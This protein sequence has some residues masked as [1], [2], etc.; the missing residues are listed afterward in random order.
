[1]RGFLPT[2]RNPAVASRP[3]S[4][5][6]LTSGHFEREDTRRALAAARGVLHSHGQIGRGN[7]GIAYKGKLGSAPALVKFAADA[8]IHGFPW[9]RSEQTKNLMQEAGVANELAALGFTV[10]P[11]AVYVELGDGT[12]AVVREYGEPL[13]SLS[14]AEYLAL[15][16]Q[17]TDIERVHGW[18]VADDLQLYRRADG[19]I[20]VADVGYWRAPDGHPWDPADSMLSTYFTRVQEEFMPSSERL[21]PL[22]RMYVAIERLGKELEDEFLPEWDG[23]DWLAAINNGQTLREGIDARTPLGWQPPAEFLSAIARL[24]A[25]LQELPEGDR[26]M[27]EVARLWRLSHPIRRPT[28]AAAWHA[29]LSAI[30]GRL[31]PDLARAWEGLSPDQRKTTRATFDA[32]AGIVGQHAALPTLPNHARSAHSAGRRR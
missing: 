16:A 15:E 30:A 19:E 6:H 18:T 5:A 23:S 27:I 29:E 21:V 12:P 17:L 31:A 10:V 28:D 14:R 20:F 25:A 26:L 3:D 2:V 24:G 13:T 8:N 22:P 9:T 11:E 1:M 32:M 7:F 4:P